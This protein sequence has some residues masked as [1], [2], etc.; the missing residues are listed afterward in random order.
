MYIPVVY[1]IGSLTNVDGFTT[2]PEEVDNIIDD[3][4]DN[5]NIDDNDN[6]IDNDDNMCDN[7][8]DD[9]NMDDKEDI[10]T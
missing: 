8:I 7:D 4:F 6:N 2:F 3:N 9:N 5:N 10:M 1:K